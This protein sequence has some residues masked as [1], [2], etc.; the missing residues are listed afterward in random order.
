MQEIA[1]GPTEDGVSTSPVLLTGMNPNL[2]P[3]TRQA[4]PSVLCMSWLNG[5]ETSMKRPKK[6]AGCW[7]LCVQEPRLRPGLC[8]SAQGIPRSDEHPS[9]TVVWA[10][11]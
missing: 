2:A 5:F 9:Q 7:P 1:P 3:S 10:R 6:E 11:P 8:A 4:L